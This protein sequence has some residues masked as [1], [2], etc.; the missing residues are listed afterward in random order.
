MDAE[1]AWE[2]LLL[3]FEAELTDPFAS[4]HG[5]SWSVPTGVGPLPPEFEGRARK[6]LLQQLDLVEELRQAQLETGRHLAAL[7]S[8]PQDAGRLPVYLDITG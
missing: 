7:Q 6:I 1:T 8:I 2:N 5:S 3:Q 4:V